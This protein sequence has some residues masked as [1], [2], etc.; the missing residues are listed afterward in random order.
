[1]TTASRHTYLMRRLQSVLNAAAPPRSTTGTVHRS[2]VGGRAF[3]VAGSQLWNTL[4]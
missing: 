1:M 2:T 4:P 3:P